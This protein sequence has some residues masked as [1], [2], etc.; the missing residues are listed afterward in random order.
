MEEVLEQ[1]GSVPIAVVAK[2][3]RKSKTW[4][5]AGIITGYLPIGKA[6]KD[7]KI[8]SSLDEWKKVEG[9]VNFYVSPLLLFNETGFKWK[10]EEQ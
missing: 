7:G 9:R 5:R 1:M 10:G 4:V 6:T 3:Y 8:I 2:V